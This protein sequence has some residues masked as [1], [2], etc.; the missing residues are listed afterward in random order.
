[1]RSKGV[2]S[3]A[4]PEIV[5]ELLTASPRTYTRQ[6]LTAAADFSTRIRLEEAANVLAAA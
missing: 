6:S 3:H 1:M 4:Q 2:V 5:I